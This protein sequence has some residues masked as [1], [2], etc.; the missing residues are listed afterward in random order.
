MRN[1][2]LTLTVTL[3]AA[4]LATASLASA[5]TAA[6]TATPAASAAPTATPAKRHR[7]K[8]VAATP[9]PATA[10]PT[11]A[12]TSTPAPAMAG[13][14]PAATTRAEKKAASSKAAQDLASAT[15]AP[16]GGPGMVWVN[17]KSNVYHQST[18]RYYGKTKVGKYM[19]E[20]DAKAAG[21]HAAP[22]NE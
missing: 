4:L 8:P 19:T 5:Q 7:Q 17:T 11:P 6:P 18:S 3:T 20:S 10:T 13:P 21:A 12:M 1:T 16:G 9:A 15:P 2:Y 14:S 22:H